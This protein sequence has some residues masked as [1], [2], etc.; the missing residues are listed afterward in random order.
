MI[1]S[2]LMLCAENVIRDAETNKISVFNIFEKIASPGFPLFIQK[3]L[4]FNRIE[5]AKDDPRQIDCELKIMN[6]DIELLKKPL[7]V[8]FQ[9]RMRNRTI[10]DISGL[11]VPNPGILKVILSYAER[12]LN[13]Y[14]II[15]NRIGEPQV[16]IQGENE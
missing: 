14:E 13:S 5:R 3:L 16:E 4:V 2:K 12:D 6:N 1:I 11:T 9:D 8:D 7:R 15:V 10:V